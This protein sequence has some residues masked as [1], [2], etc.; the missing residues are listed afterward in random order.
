MKQF[1][2]IAALSVVVIFSLAV[3][4]R[5]EIRLSGEVLGAGDGADLARIMELNDC[6]NVTRI[7]RLQTVRLYHLD[8]DPHDYLVESEKEGEDWVIVSVERLRE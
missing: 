1:W 6:D 2:G 4:S 3:L 8:C 5:S 7:R